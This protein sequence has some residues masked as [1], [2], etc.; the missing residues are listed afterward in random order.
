MTVN[1][2]DI[3][4]TRVPLP[5]ELAEIVKVLR[6]HKKWSQATLAEIAGVTERTIQRVESGVASSLDTRRALARA[7]EFEG[8]DIFE[9]WP[10]PN[11]AK[12]KAYEAELDKTTVVVPLTRIRDG[13]TLRMMT[14]GAFGSVAEELGQISY[15]AREA[16]AAMVDYLRDYNDIREMYSMSQRI[17]V[18][19]EI[20][21]F[22][23]T[24]SDEHAAVGAG[25]RHARVRSNDSPNCEAMDWTN[26]FVVLAP[27][28]VLPPNI[29][30]PRKF[31]LR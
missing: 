25:L 3:V 30:V 15:T 26:I 27:D 16:C 13:R 9:K 1:P 5:A 8:L 10:F 2:E 17:E 11:L 20:E 7:F 19:H 22:L 21:A 31:S 18:D 14:E 23:K 12:L 4:E 6:E 28:N 24:I 29:R